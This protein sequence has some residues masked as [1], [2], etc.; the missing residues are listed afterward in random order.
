MV[1]TRQLD[2]TVASGVGGKWTKDVIRGRWASVACHRS[3]CFD[4]LNRPEYICC[5]M[6]YL[7]DLILILQ[8]VF[9][10][11]LEDRFT[12]KV[13]PDS[14]NEIVYE[15]VCSERMKMVHDAITAIVRDQH[16]PA[17][18]IMMSKVETLLKENKVWNLYLGINSLLISGRSRRK[19]CN[20]FKRDLLSHRCSRS[21]E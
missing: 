18:N 1:F 19:M 5:L 9:Q 13:T 20:S 15:F 10:I 8:A 4:L 14:V 11:L 2:L 7:V 6:I 21:L 17:G 12:G 16:S 3:R